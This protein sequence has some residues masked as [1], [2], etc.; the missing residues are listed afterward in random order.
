MKRDREIEDTD[1]G[2]QDTPKMKIGR[3]GAKTCREAKK[4]ACKRAWIEHA[5][6]NPEDDMEI[7]ET[8]KRNQDAAVTPEPNAMLHPPPYGDKETELTNQRAGAAPKVGE[9]THIKHKPHETVRRSTSRPKRAHSAGNTPS[10]CHSAARKSKSCIPQ[11][12]REP[13]TLNTRTPHSTKM[14]YTNTV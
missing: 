2:N 1:K 13:A 3:E 10:T 11:R 6:H 12:W 4:R 14:D 8:D 9:L 7:E 5:E